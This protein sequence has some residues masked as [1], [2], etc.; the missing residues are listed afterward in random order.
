[1]KN[2]PPLFRFTFNGSAVKA[3]TRLFADYCLKSKFHHDSDLVNILLKIRFSCF[4]TKDCRRLKPV[5]E[6]L[7][8]QAN[9]QVNKRRRFRSIVRR[10]RK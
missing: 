1:M 7:V 8:P 6:K 2:F 5:P 10:K 4:Q 9:P 3:V